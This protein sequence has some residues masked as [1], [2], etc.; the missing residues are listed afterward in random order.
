MHFCSSIHAIWTSPNSSIMCSHDISIKPRYMHF[1][2][3]KMCHNVQIGNTIALCGFVCIPFW[4]LYFGPTPA[5]KI[6]TSNVGN[7]N[8]ELYTSTWLKR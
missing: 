6:I 4:F 8:L 2:C 1:L 5:F 3:H 7:L